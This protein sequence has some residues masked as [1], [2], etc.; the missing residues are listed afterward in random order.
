MRRKQ[1]NTAK[2]VFL[3]GELSLVEEFATLCARKGYTVFLK[4]G[5]RVS[6]SSRRTKAVRTVRD[7]PRAVSLAVELTNIDS[8]QKKKNL[9]AL[10]KKLPSAVPLI[11]TSVAVTATEQATW[12]KHKHRVIGFSGLPTFIRSHLLE[13]APTVYTSATALARTKEFL[14]SLGLEI[15]VVQDRVGM[16]LPR[17]LSSLINE[18]SFAV[19]E[20]VASPED[21]DV[22]MKLGTNYPRGPI[23]WGQRIGFDQ[24]LTVLTALHKD[25]GDDRYRPAPLL[26]QLALTGNFWKREREKL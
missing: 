22:A 9:V 4:A 1:G 21:I 7:I 11:S 23:E 20:D 16:V 2:T 19:M 3:V 26:R 6:S 10:D 5:M 13:V 18:A 17:I 15:S 14:W 25:L 8:D 24:I 12:I